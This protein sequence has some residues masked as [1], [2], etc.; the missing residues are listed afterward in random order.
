MWKMSFTG[1]R[2]EWRGVLR[3]VKAVS[4]RRRGLLTL[5]LTGWVQSTWQS[6][7]NSS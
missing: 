2:G 6:A 1:S 5:R 7:A 3:V 4:E